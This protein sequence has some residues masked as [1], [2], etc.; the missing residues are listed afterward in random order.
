[1]VA[2]V[3]ESVVSAI[4][5]DRRQIIESLEAVHEVAVEYWARFT[6]DEFFAPIGEHW[7]PSE[8]VRHLTRSMTPLLPVL[9]VPRVAL[10][11]AFGTAV[12]SSRSMAEIE[13]AYT[14]ALASGGTAGRFAPPPEKAA[15]D[16]VRRNFIM[17]AHSETLRGLTQAVERWSEAQL[18]A[19][20]LPHPL[21]GKLTVREMLLFTLL[22][23][24][25]HVDVVERRRRELG[26][27]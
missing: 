27:A 23:N 26:R 13:A 22:H 2:V 19:H 24:Q 8:H 12:G 7:S 20:R 10:R 21:L 18:D 4:V 9:R 3:K 16:L 5:P 15:P 25:H 11:M 6:T 1:M 14:Q 17:D